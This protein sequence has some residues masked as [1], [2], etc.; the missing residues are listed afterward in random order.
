MTK[1][2]GFGGQLR[3]PYKQAGFDRFCPVVWLQTMVGDRLIV[4]L[5]FVFVASK[6]LSIMGAQLG[7]LV[8]FV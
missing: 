4:T 3:G 7:E 1:A 6:E 2:Q 8:L 5:L